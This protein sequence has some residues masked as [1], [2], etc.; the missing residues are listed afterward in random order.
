MLVKVGYN[1]ERLWLSV[2]SNGNDNF[3]GRV[4]NHPINPG[5][6]FGQMIQI[7]IYKLFWKLYLMINLLYINI[8]FDKRTKANKRWEDNDGYF[9]R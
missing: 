5:L 7:H 4:W 1:G 3:V 9:L 2:L 6:L 8:M